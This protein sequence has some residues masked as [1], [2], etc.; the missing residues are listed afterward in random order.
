MRKIEM[1]KSGGGLQ[2]PQKILDLLLLFLNCQKAMTTLIYQ[3]ENDLSTPL[4]APL[5]I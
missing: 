3:S 2:V 4:D 1:F 5:Y